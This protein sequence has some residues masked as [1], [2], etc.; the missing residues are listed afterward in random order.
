VR[1][2]AALAGWLGTSEIE[3]YVADN[4]DQPDLLLKTIFKGGIVI[5]LFSQW[6]G[7][8]YRVFRQETYC[9]GLSRVIRDWI[10]APL[11][12]KLLGS[13]SDPEISSCDGSGSKDV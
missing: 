9:I 11:A 2:A 3:P 4:T 6:A 7:R 5:T 1:L 13:L 8:Q 12:A 10:L